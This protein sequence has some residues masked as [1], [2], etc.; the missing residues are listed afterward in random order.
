MLG[1]NPERGDFVT[2]L[3]AYLIDLVPHR[4]PIRVIVFVLGFVRRLVPALGLRDGLPLVGPCRSILGLAYYVRLP[5]LVLVQVRRHARQED[6]EAAQW[7]PRTIPP[8]AST[9]EPRCCALLA[10]SCNSVLLFLAY[11][12]ILGEE[13]KGASGHD[14]QVHLHQG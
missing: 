1:E 7:C 13:R 3:I 6:D 9:L 2:R 10:T 4:D 8:V 11:L 5:A 14:L 12:L